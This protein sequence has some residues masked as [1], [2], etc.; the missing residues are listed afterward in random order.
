MVFASAL[1]CANGARDR[2]VQDREATDRRPSA[3]QTRQGPDTLP[4]AFR[5]L[6]VGLRLPVL[7]APTYIVSNPAL[8]AASCH[9]RIAGAFPALNAPGSCMLDE[10]LN[11]IEARTS[12][13]SA[14]VSRAA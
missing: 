10:W 12:R 1:L 2:R 6:V 8:V 14:D 9:A 11:R 7:G 13:A 3:P 4:S 5:D